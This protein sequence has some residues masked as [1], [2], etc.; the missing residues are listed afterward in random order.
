MKVAD[1]PIMLL[2]DPLR[3][4]LAILVAGL[5]LIMS[6]EEASA[7]W[8]ELGTALKTIYADHPGRCPPLLAG[9]LAGERA[10]GREAVPADRELAAENALERLIAY[11]HRPSAPGDGVAAAGSGRG[12]TADAAEA[13]EGK[14]SSGVLGRAIGKL[15]GR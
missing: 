7:F 11:A 8:A 4:E 15:R 3:C 13:E 14:P 9:L 12:V 5:R 2:T 1:A 6:A 10:V